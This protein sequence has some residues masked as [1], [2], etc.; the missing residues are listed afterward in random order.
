MLKHLYSTQWS[1]CIG[2]DSQAA[3]A[4][5]DYINDATGDESKGTE[6]ITKGKKI[7]SSRDTGFFSDS[8]LHTFKR[9]HQYILLNDLME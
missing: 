4:E 5:E 7:K 6:I 1:Y 2:L 3:E 9:A 8:M